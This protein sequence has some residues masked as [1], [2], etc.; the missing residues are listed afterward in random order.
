M[1]TVVA[2]ANVLI[3]FIHGGLI[4]LVFE[5]PMR[6]I[7]PDILYDDE[8]AENHAYLLRL[9][10][11]RVELSGASVA[12]LAAM[13]QRQASVSLYDLSALI[14][15]AQESCSLLTG[16]KKLRQVAKEEGVTLGG[17]IWL[18]RQ[19]HAAGMQ[20]ASAL[21]Q[22]LQRMRDEGSRL[23]WSEVESMLDELK[24]GERE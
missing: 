2:D 20:N 9:G 5:L 11:K 13:R 24:F 23:P 15:A 18:A 21:K 8:L 14:L 22:A 7:T 6:I 1:I 10:L 19:L 16:D 12:L 17:T 4:S 3:D